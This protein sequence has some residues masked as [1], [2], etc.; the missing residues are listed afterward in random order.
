VCSDRVPLVAIGA[1]TG[2]PPALA[3]ILAQWPT[4]FPA[5]VVIVQH[6]DVE[7]APQLAHWLGARSKVKVRLAIAG[8][9]P[10]PGTVLIAGTNDHL[11]MTPDRS[12]RYT[13]EPADNPYR[14]SVDALFNSL[15]AHW[16]APGIAAL[17]TG[18]GR[19]G[20]VGLLRLRKA[21]WHTLA[22][23]E[24]SSVIYGMPKAAVELGGAAAIVPLDEMAQQI[25]AHPLVSKR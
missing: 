10:Q 23:D 21:G 2:G 22:Q 15:A 13:P 24:A 19:D 25:Q 14:P 18:I 17:L 16:P 12:L 6:I 1:S 7:F 4:D 5:A 3:A 8:E 9:R 20:A 11:V